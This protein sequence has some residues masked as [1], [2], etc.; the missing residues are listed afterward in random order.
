MPSWS[1]LKY[2]PWGEIAKAARRVP[3]F[4]RDLRKD[5][6]DDQ[7]PAPSRSA[8][9]DTPPELAQLRFELELLKANIEKLRA[10]S[11]TQGRAL[12][13]QARALTQISNA[14]A[15]RLRTAAWVAGLALIVALAAF[16]TA[17]LR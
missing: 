11:E 2:A 8:S 4:V 12:E 10:H 16:V 9:P 6:D 3:E 15:A 1:W 17:L 14:H 7:A 13:E 5:D